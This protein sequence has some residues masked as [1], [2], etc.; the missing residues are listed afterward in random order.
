MVVFSVPIPR[1]EENKT[2]SR[3]RPTIERFPPKSFIVNGK[4]LAFQLLGSSP[5]GSKTFPIQLEDGVKEFPFTACI[6][7][8]SCGFE[9]NNFRSGGNRN[10]EMTNARCA[11]CSARYPG[12]MRQ[13][14]I[15]HQDA[16]KLFCAFRICEGQQRPIVYFLRQQPGTFLA[17]CSWDKSCSCLQQAAPSMF[18]TEEDVTL[19]P[20]SLHQYI[21]EC[22]VSNFLLVTD[23][24][25]FASIEAFEAAVRAVGKYKPVADVVV[26]PKTKKAK[27]NTVAA[28]R[29]HDGAKKAKVTKINKQKASLDKLAKD[30]IDNEAEE[31]N[32]S[33][34]EEDTSCNEALVSSDE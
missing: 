19:I 6:C 28:K 16:N 9:L 4:P 14:L 27:T 8:K 24:K 25:A 31:A 5:D 3:G 26:S 18:Y 23:K 32:P 7:G 33:S 1:S 22:G 17:Q 15:D 34:S 12:S 10:G 11:N 21:E 20:D 30:Y 13:F 2:N 29:A